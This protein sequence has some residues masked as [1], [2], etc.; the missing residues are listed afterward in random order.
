LIIDNNP[1]QFANNPSGISP[2]KDKEEKDEKAREEI[3]QLRK[4][5][6]EQKSN[7]FYLIL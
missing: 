5:F 1:S 6:L 3:V 2:E 4:K 7:H